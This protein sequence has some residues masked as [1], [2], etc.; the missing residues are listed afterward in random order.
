[1]KKVEVSIQIKTNPE[2]VI[3]AFTDSEL[4]KAWWGVEKSLIQKKV[5]GLYTLAWNVSQN[6][7][8]Y[9]STGIIE[10]YDPKHELVIRDFAY[11]NPD[12]PFLGPMTLTVKTREA[13]GCTDVYLCQDGYQEGAHWDWYFEAV[14]AA[15]PEVMK[16]LKEYL[17]K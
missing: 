5:G 3:K 10:K 16:E 7:I 13:N 6:A 2:N 14:K 17:E 15:W 12:K 9:V 8:G 1:M 11:L 4:L